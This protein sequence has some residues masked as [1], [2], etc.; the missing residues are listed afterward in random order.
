MLLV[1][2]V[3]VRVT[4]GNPAVRQKKIGECLGNRRKQC[5]RIPFLFCVGPRP[6]NFQDYWTDQDQQIGRA[7]GK[8]IET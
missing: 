4:G 3:R 5:F 7:R 8:T 2:T 6:L 1:R